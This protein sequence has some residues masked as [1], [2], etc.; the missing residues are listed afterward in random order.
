[1]FIFNKLLIYY[2]N[3]NQLSYK[4]ERSYERNNLFLFNIFSN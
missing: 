1:M 2:T 3:Y 4:K